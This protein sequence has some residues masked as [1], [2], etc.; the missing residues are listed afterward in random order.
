MISGR[1]ERDAGGGMSPDQFRAN[2]HRI[3]DWIADYWRDIDARAVALPTKPGDTL[4]RLPKSPPRKGE[5]FD[6]IWRD[7]QDVII[8]NSVHWQSP[9][10]F[11]YFACNTSPA[12]VLGEMLAAAMASANFQWACNPAATEL[13]MRVMDWLADMLALPSSFKFEN[14]GGGAIQET[15]SVAGLVAL[16]AARERAGGAASDLTAY[17]TDETHSHAAKNLRVAGFSPAQIRVVPTDETLAMDADKF[18]ALLAEDRRAG[19]RPCFVTA[20]VGTTSTCAIDDLARIG[21]LCRQYGAWLHADAAMAGAAALCPEYRAPFA[22]AE[23]AD[24]FVFNPH[25]SLFV[26]LQCSAFFVKDRRALEAALR[27]E[28]EYMRNPVSADPDSAVTDYRNWSISLGR[29]FRALKLWMVIRSFGV[30]GLQHYVRKHIKLARQLADWIE[31][32]D[33][34]ELAAPLNFNL[35][36]LRHRD[37]D[38]ATERI[39]NQIN[40][41]GRALVTRSK[42]RGAVIMRAHIAQL[43]TE[44]KHIQNL[45]RQ[46]QELA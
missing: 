34:F 20:T 30:E 14:S 5:P 31:A 45:W 40:A 1:D 8:P 39:I 19:R 3:V 9:N 41:S 37:G 35:V 4:K 17:L 42:A 29:S 44:L 28:P 46:I 23:L 10:F 26:N 13:E 16:T 43:N 33:R 7:M 18:A 27:F 6:A 22:G 12:S 11:G 38:T 25:K 24:S 15:A 36:C 32:D 2:A 21:E